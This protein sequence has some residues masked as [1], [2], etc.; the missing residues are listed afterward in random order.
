MSHNFYQISIKIKNTL[1]H[2][3]LIYE[4]HCLRNN[5]TEGI[6]QHWLTSIFP[7]KCEKFKI[8]IITVTFH[9]DQTLIHQLRDNL[10]A[11]KPPKPDSLVSIR[12][13]AC[14]LVVLGAVDVGAVVEG[15]VSSP[16]G[17]PP[18]LVEKMPVEARKGSVLR[19]LVLEEQRAL[20]CP[21][22]LQVPK[23]TKKTAKKAFSELGNKPK[24]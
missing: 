3:R 21:E 8:L 2:T 20:L 22:L 5:W 9:S 11:E 1:P 23:T 16:D 6:K 13:E 7:H 19:A 4:T 24:A 12:A 18:T 15:S 14:G 10:G 17:S